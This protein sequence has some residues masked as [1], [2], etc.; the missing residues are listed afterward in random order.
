MVNK[1]QSKQGR[2]IKINFEDAKAMA[3]G[4]LALAERLASRL[5]L[6]S[7][8]EKNLPK[9]RGHYDWLTIIK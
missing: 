7:H 9:R 8:L 2:A 5:G 6:W 3:F 1:N 4:G